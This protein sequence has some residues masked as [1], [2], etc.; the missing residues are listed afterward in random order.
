MTDVCILG[1]GPA[2]LMATIFA[3]RQGK[4]A[5]IIDKNER[6]LKLLISGKG[7]CNVTNNCDNNT[8]LKNVVGNPKFLYSA[9]N[10]LNPSELMNF[11]EELGVLLKTERG[12]RVFPQSDKS[13]DVS[14][15]LLNECKR[16]KVE[17]KIGTV[18]SLDMQGKQVVAAVLNSGE[19]VFAKTFVLAM[20]GKSYP[21]T[22][23]DGSGFS[24]A[25]SLGHAV[26]G[27]RAGLVPLETVE[28]WPKEIA[29][30]AL[31]NVAITVKNAE[32]GKTIYKDFG[33][34]LFTHFGVS[35]PIILSASSFLKDKKS[36]QIS[37]DLKPALSEEILNKRILRDFEKNS[38]ALFK[39]SLN[40]LLPSSLVP[41]I[42]EKSGILPEKKVAEISKVER[43]NLMKTLKNL[44]LNIAKKRGFDEAIV[45]QGGVLLN[46]INPATMRSKLVGNLYFAG[47]II[48]IDAL[49][50]G[51]NL[52]IAFSTGALAGASIV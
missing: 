46:E 9:L 18:K 41:I 20:G 26:S 4:S 19:K 3:A 24:L 43:K 14:N 15:A 1:G 16:L 38:K 27:L 39:N 40:A 50:G 30:L 45:T 32:N 23:S 8:V 52:Q 13:L 28:N 12:G 47:E 17:R 6:P 51:F 35:G 36:A 7:R 21:R 25:E 44:E 5:I 42:I 22:G 34:M 11:F 29:G 48:D 37:I 31:K 49:T 2:G 33:E 10:F